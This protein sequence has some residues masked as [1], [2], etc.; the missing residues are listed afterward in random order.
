MV[1]AAIF[2]QDGVIVK[3]SPGLEMYLH[4]GK[5]MSTY[6]E[7]MK[8]L[9]RY[10][11]GELTYDE[12]ADLAVPLF[13]K[14]FW[15]YKQEEVQDLAK[16]VMAPMENQIELVK[17]LVVELKKRGYVTILIS[18]GPEECANISGAKIPFDYVHGFKI[19]Y[20]KKSKTGLLTPVLGS[21]GKLKI[22]QDIA[23]EL[24]IEL[25]KSL[26]VGDSVGDL[27][28][29]SAVGMPFA[30][31]GNAIAA[32]DDDLVRIAKEKGWKVIN[33]LEEILDYI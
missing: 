31:S 8:V 19:D 16:K 7:F 22:L 32:N 11:N 4:E 17:K 14:A 15:S 24:G 25:E 6:D 10:R 12:F 20:S 21:K 2:D 28:I 18:A 5:K 3:G 26:A 1:K 23:K 9:E 29:L 27:G 33:S 13:A 30:I